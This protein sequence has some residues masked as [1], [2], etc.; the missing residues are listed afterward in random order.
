MILYSSVCSREAGAGRVKPT[1]QASE[2][3]RYKVAFTAK[4]SLGT[5]NYAEVQKASQELVRSYLA[6][7]AS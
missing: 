4:R 5:M 2:C 7:E 1:Q 6:Y 3:K